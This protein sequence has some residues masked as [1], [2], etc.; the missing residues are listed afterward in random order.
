MV[1]W[2]TLEGTRAFE[3]S[4]RKAMRRLV[5]AMFKRRP[6]PD[7]YGELCTDEEFSASIDDIELFDE[8]GASMPLPAL[9]KSLKSTWIVE[10]DRYGRAEGCFEPFALRM[11][12]GRLVL[13]GGI[14]ELMRLELQRAMGED[15]V[16]ARIAAPADSERVVEYPQGFGV[17]D[18]ETRAAC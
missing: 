7:R 9:P 17:H 6:K 15:L 13:E 18:C 5:S 8:E 4:R 12:C 14:R 16:V 11:E 10:Y 1:T 3:R 2:K